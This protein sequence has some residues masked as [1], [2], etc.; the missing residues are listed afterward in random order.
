VSD[1]KKIA[2]ELKANGYQVL[3]AYDVTRERFLDATRW[4]VFRGI[5]QAGR[6]RRSCT[7]PGMA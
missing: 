5:T 7:M 1:A 3:E 4:N 2:A 6:T